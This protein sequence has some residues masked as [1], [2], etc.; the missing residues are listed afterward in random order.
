[1]LV[2]RVSRHPLIQDVVV[3]LS[4]RFHLRARLDPVHPVV[5]LAG[6]PIGRTMVLATQSADGPTVWVR[7]GRDKLRIPAP[8]GKL[9][10]AQASLDRVYVLIVGTLWFHPLPDPGC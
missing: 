3:H 7:K 8:A 10:A 9:L 1:M 4:A 6:L 2:L 5:Y